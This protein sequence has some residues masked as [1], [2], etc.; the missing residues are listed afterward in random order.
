MS[1]GFMK[2]VKEYQASQQ[3]AAATNQAQGSGIFSAA[4]HQK[5]AATHRGSLHV[6]S[7]KVRK[8]ASMEDKVYGAGIMVAHKQDP[9]K[10]IWGCVGLRQDKRCPKQAPTCTIK[11][12]SFNNPLWLIP[13]CESKTSVKEAMNLARAQYEAQYGVWPYAWPLPG[14]PA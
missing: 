4:S 2:E 6:T 11:D 10:M 5:A 14:A 3:R 1:A 9:K 8:N 7:T 12:I 13:P